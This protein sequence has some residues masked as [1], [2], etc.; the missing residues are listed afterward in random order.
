MP[1]RLVGRVQ[2]DEWAGLDKVC[3]GA[4]GEWSWVGEEAVLSKWCRRSFTS[5][6]RRL[7]ARRS[8]YNSFSSPSNPAP[9]ER[10]GREEERKGEEGLGQRTSQPLN[11]CPLSPTPPTHRL[12]L[13]AWCARPRTPSQERRC[14]SRSSFP[15]AW[16]QSAVA[17]FQPRSSPTARAVLQQDH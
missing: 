2:A 6:Q 14:S 5:I 11:F 9:F 12:P 3:S 8:W 1:E 4:V 15:P 7:R 10:T 17:A 16:V 13:R